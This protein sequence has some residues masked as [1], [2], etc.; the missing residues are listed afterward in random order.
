MFKGV[1]QT[2]LYS[3]FTSDHQVNQLPDNSWV[4]GDMQIMNTESIKFTH[5]N[6]SGNL[7]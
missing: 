1:I 2:N 5:S 3:T 6:P 7:N 4:L